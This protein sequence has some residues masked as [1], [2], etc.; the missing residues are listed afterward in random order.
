MWSTAAGGFASVRITDE[1]ASALEEC[2]PSP[3]QSR[4]HH[5]HVK[6]CEK[7]MPAYSGVFDTAFTRP[8]PPSYIYALP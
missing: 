7:V 4:Q 5:R 2:I 6:A 1:V 8:C 3:P